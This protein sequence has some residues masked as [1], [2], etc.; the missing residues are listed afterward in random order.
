[1]HNYVHIPLAYKFQ[2]FLPAHRIVQAGRR[3]SLSMEHL[4]KYRLTQQ[5]L[6][7]V[8]FNVVRKAAGWLSPKRHGLSERR[9]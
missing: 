7:V 1:M 8:F 3:H 4:E 6:G 5:H 9:E 2:S